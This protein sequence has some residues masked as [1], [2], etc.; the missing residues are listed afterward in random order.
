MECKNE[1]I[2]DPQQTKESLTQLLASLTTFIDASTALV[3]NVKVVVEATEMLPPN[4]QAPSKQGQVKSQQGVNQSLSYNADEEIEMEC[5]CPKICEIDYPDNQ[6]SKTYATAEV[7]V[8]DKVPTRGVQVQMPSLI[9]VEK[10]DSPKSE[11][12]N[13]DKTGNDSGKGEDKSVPKS[14]TINSNT[15]KIDT[16][17][18]EGAPPSESKTQQATALAKKNRKIAEEKC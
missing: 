6:N 4:K 16:S 14:D 12:E 10:S 11:G 2:T 9:D 1:A 13:A 5:T 7:P 15:S 17:S 3:H 8:Q 18:L